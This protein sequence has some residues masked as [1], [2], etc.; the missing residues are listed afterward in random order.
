MADE[1][2]KK[3]PSRREVLY[4]RGKNKK[5]A[6]KA[7]DK[8]PEAKAA[9]KTPDKPAEG[10]APGSPMEGF[11]GEM[12]ALNKRHEAE[13]R[14]HHGNTREAMRKMATRHAQDF[15]DLAQRQADTM[16]KMSPP[17]EMP[18]AGEA[19]GGGAQVAEGA[20]PPVA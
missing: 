11:A 18:A 1:E 16:A 3:K 5:S 8:K 2:T 7:P 10:E 13:R 9:V 12:D 14:D 6:D 20:A 4:D 15:K 19:P 17:A